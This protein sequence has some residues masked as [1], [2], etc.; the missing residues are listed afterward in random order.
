MQPAMSFGIL[1]LFICYFTTIRNSYSIHLQLINKLK[2]YV[3]IQVIFK[4][5]CKFM[6][7]SWI[8]ENTCKFTTVFLKLLTK[9]YLHA[10][11]FVILDGC[12]CMHQHLVCCLCKEIISF[13]T[14]DSST[15]AIEGYQQHHHPQYEF[16]ITIVIV[17]NGVQSICIHYFKFHIGHFI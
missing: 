5:W 2:L 13:A 12:T 10:L 3:M 14:W 8:L 1:Q 9:N 6:S 4:S 11:W 15:W 16:T 17:T 7:I